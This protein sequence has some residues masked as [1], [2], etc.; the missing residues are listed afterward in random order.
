EHA[1]VQTAVGALMGTFG[2]MAP[3]QVRGQPADARSDLFC[4]GCVLFEMV[5]GR[6]AFARATP[7]DSVAAL[8]SD[9]PPD[10]GKPDPRPPRA[11]ERLIRRCLEKRP[12]DRF[13]SAR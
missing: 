6:R 11:V 13:Q 4:L 9:A 5:A 12:E 8:L 1:P 2:Y 7:A 10:M 3:E